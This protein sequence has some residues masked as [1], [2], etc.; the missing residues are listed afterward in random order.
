MGK[1]ASRP[2][3][4]ETWT[5][6]PRFSDVGYAPWRFAI[7]PGTRGESATSEQVLFMQDHAQEGVVDLDS[8]VIVMNEAQFPE[9]IHEQ[10]DPGARCTHHFR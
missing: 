3:P 9:F 10:V 7:N 1:E 8:A 2:D 5:T 4:S 6:S